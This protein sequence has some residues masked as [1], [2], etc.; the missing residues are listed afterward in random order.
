[1]GS[2]LR[3]LGFALVSLGVL[4][5][6]SPARAT[7]VWRDQDLGAQGIHKGAGLP[8]FAVYMDGAHSSF[9]TQELFEKR[10][11]PWTLFA[12]T[13]NQYYYADSLRD[14]HGHD[15]PGCFHISTFL[16]VQRLLPLDAPPH[17]AACSTSSRRFP[18]SWRPS[19]RSEPSP[20]RPW[21]PAILRSAPASTFRRSTRARG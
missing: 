11:P 1:M 9:A 19:L 15:V 14:D 21:G 17:R 8:L 5:R 16:L 4:W 3:W 2:A 20:L 18:S 12:G 7:L 10:T 6:P 13:Y